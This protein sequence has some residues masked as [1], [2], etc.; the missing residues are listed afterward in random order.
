MIQP[1]EGGREFF[2]AS[3]S[4]LVDVDAMIPFTSSMLLGC[5]SG[6]YNNFVIIEPPVSTKWNALLFI[7]FLSISI[8]QFSL[9]SFFPST[10]LGAYFACMLT[11][12]CWLVSKQEKKRDP[13]LFTLFAREV[14]T[15]VYPDRSKWQKL[16]QI[17]ITVQSTA[18]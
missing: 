16:V 9:F 14:R 13:T 6:R 17:G 10:L 4:Y 7:S 8:S 11:R 3:W 1:V 15:K 18:I 5:R 2:V 12:F